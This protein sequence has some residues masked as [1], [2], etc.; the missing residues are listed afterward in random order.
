MSEAD[1]DEKFMDC[2]GRVIGEKGA[3]ALLDLAQK[4]G[5][6]TDVR[7]LAQAT[8]P[9]SGVSAQPMSPAR[10]PAA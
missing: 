9:A 5:Q 6:L 8:L 4:C 2:A 7:I 10:V 3:R 1:R